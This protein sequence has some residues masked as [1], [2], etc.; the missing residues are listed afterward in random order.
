MKVYKNTIVWLLLQFNSVTSYLCKYYFD[1]YHPRCCR[2]STPPYGNG[3]PQRQGPPP[4]GQCT[5]KPQKTNA[6]EQRAW[7]RFADIDLAFKLPWSQ[8]NI[9]KICRNNPDPQRPHPETIRTKRIR[10]PCTQ[11]ETPRGPV[12]MSL[13]FRA[14][15]LVEGW[16]TQY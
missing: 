12:S 1:T 8:T 11:Q 5:V 7:Q 14:I 15:L 3:S 9:R 10:C 6:Q 4:V 13:R 2:L 16:P